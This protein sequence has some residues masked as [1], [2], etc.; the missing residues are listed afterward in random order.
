MSKNG[1]RRP[2][3]EEIANGA[4]SNPPSIDLNRAR[5]IKLLDEAAAQ[6]RITALRKRVAAIQQ[7][8]HADDH[9]HALLKGNG[10]RVSLRRDIL[11]AELEQVLEA[12]TLERARYYLRRL[13]RGVA[14]EQTN[15]IND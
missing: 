11:A 3:V 9:R 2:V 6:P 10:H 15:A 7:T 4:S 14:D 8:I 5:F 12:R 1:K 13:A